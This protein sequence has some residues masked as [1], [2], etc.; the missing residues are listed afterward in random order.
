VVNK[1]L[2]SKVFIEYYGTGWEKEYRE[3]VEKELETQIG[4]YLEL[5]NGDDK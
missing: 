1:D 4:F 3:R 5:I 2:I